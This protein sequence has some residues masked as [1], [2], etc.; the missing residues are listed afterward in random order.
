MDE[1]HVARDIKWSFIGIVA[2][3][4]IVLALLAYPIR[5]N[6]KLG[7]QGAK[8]NAAL[9]AQR[10]NI[11]ERIAASEEL[12]ETDTSGDIFGIPRLF[13]QQ[14]IDRDKRQLVAFAVLD[15]E[16]G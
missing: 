7:K 3:A 12:L 5:E 11:R 1:N 14:S 9:C 13:I 10:V 16:D 8:A 6:R 2:L 4:F 15:C